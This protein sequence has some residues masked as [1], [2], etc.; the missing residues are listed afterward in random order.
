MIGHLCFGESF[1]GL[2]LALLHP[3]VAGIFENAKANAYLRSA[4]YLTNYRS[5]TNWMIPKALMERRKKNAAYTVE[6]VDRRLNTKTDRIDLMSKM[7]DPA[8]GLSRAEFIANSTTV[9]VAG[10]ETTATLLAGVTYYLVKN[11][12]ILAKVTNEVR[13]TFK[14]E[15]EITMSRTNELKY[16]LACLE[17][18]LRMYPPVPG[19]FPRR[20]DRDDTICG[21]YV[22][23]GVSISPPAFCFV[24]DPTSP[25]RYVY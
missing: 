9:I 13:S 22:P 6:K 24:G 20:T 7:F 5:L 1:R 21:K 10:S 14:S 2:E 23:A 3:W 17:E 15:D 19:A 18:A 8:S 16:L 25:R 4:N 11:P 12:E